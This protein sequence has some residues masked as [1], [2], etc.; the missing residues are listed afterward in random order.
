MKQILVNLYK[1]SE[2]SESAQ[3]KA[4]D[5]HL[6]ILTYWNWWEYIYE[7]AKRIGL[8]IHSFDLYPDSI[9]IRYE[10]D[11]EYVANQIFKEWG[12]L[13]KMAELANNY[14]SSAAKCE[15]IETDDELIDSDELIKLNE[16]FLNDL[17][18][19][20]LNFLQTDYEWRT[21]DSAIGEELELQDFYFLE[22][23]SR[24]Y[25]N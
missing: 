15:V 13:T 21:S 14:L 6:D 5:K 16:D 22:D 25:N 8:S 11:P 20:F 23:G 19:H 9:D 17:G 3:K 2:L 10:D 1:F 7:D 18:Y 12:G 4:I 24:F